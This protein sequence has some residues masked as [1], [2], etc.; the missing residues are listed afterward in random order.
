VNNFFTL[1][2]NGWKQTKN[3]QNGFRI[4]LSFQNSIGI[5]AQLNIF[6]QDSTFQNTKT[7]IDISYFI[8]YN[9]RIYWIPVTVSSDI[10]IKNNAVISDYN[11]S[12]ITSNLDYSKQDKPNSLLFTIKP[13][14][15][16]GLEKQTNNN[17]QKAAK[18]HQFFLELQASHDFF[19]NT[20]NSIA[21]RTQTII[22]TVLRI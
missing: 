16:T 21:L 8:S 18:S 5:K 10:K 15:K 12:F 7:E 1:L 14:T 4:A 20:K 22:Y 9:T 11:N 13:L 6:K 2:E 19:L 17:Q 3:I